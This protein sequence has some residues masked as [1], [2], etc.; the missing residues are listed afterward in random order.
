M[1]T[2]TPVNVFN[3]RIVELQRTRVMINIAVRRRTAWTLETE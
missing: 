2:L 3:N 1:F